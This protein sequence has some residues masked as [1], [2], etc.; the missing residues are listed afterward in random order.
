MKKPYTYIYIPQKNDFAEIPKKL[1]AHFGT[2]QF[3]I[4]LDLNENRKLANSDA[5]QVMSMLEEQGYFL[6]LPPSN[7][8]IIKEI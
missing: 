7:K 4:E 1:L 8:L 5:K 6:Q 2:P 3:V